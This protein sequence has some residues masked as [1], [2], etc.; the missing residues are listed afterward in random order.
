MYG[1]QNKIF[2]ENLRN[3]YEEILSIDWSEDSF[4]QTVDSL[5][6]RLSRSMVHQIKRW[7]T[8]YSVEDWEIEVSKLKDFYSD[9]LLFIN[10][11]KFQIN[12]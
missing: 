6:D 5:Q 12:H 10:E 9:R 11:N 4:N 2:R 3:R 8:H 7:R 1:I